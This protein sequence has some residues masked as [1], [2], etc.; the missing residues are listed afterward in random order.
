MNMNSFKINEEQQGQ[1]DYY[2][3]LWSIYDA[4]GLK[5]VTGHDIK[6]I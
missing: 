4:F 3:Y 6:D 5:D 2:I 1:Y